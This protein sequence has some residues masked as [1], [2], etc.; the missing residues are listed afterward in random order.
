MTALDMAVITGLATGFAFVVLGA[1]LVY[2][3][4]DTLPQPTYYGRL[5][6]TATRIVLGA[7]FVAALVIVV[8]S[9]GEREIA[10]RD[11]QKPGLLRDSEAHKEAAKRVL[12]AVFALLISAAAAV[13]LALGVLGAVIERSF[14]NAA[15]RRRSPSQQPDSVPK[16]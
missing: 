5:S 12:A 7:L 1:A 16:S 8:R 3:S 10:G 13:G 9:R 11:L 2:P 14:R 4:K 6:T 15:L